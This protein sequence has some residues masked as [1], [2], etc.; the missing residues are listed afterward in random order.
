MKIFGE[1]EVVKREDENIL[2]TLGLGQKMMELV[3]ITMWS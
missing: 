2:V 1:Q 3:L